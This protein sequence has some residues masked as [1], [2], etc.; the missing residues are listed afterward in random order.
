MPNER[1]PEASAAAPPRWGLG[2]A[3]AG[4][5]VGYFVSSVLAGIWLGVTG[6]EDLSL[7]GQAFSQLGL[8]AG[9]LGAPLYAA[10]R[11]G[12]GLEKDFGYAVRPIDGLFGLVL[13]MGTQYVVVPLVAIILSPL[14]GDPDVSQ[15]AR[16]LTEGA[17]GAR[18]VLLV[19][20]IV[21]ITPIVEELYFRGL[22]L[23][24]LQRRWGTVWA[25]VLSS[26][27]FGLVHL[28]QPNVEALVLAMISLSAF[29]V[30][31]ALVT[32]RTGRLG[33][34]IIGHAIFNGWTLVLI[35]T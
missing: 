24:A 10:R 8:W 14:L 18:L 17:T 7:G 30:L 20:A 31:L 26:V 33:A 1:E 2:E 9:L 13:G 4:L 22:L 28:N 12:S 21:V 35:L 27:V 25:V 29:A 19:L 32:L 15:P 34:A 6:E 16:E 5:L 11:K 23:R 3:V